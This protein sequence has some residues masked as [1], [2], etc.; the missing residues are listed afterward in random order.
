[1][2]FWLAL[3]VGLATVKGVYLAFAPAAQFQSLM[4]WWF[5]RDG[6]RRIRL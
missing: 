2:V 3:T 4:D 5:D 1:M 6:E